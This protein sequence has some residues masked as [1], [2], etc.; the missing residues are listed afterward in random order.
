MVRFPYRLVMYCSIALLFCSCRT[1]PKTEGEV[2]EKTLVRHEQKLNRIQ[3][4]APRFDFGLMGHF[5]LRF[6]GKTTDKAA[7]S[8]EEFR[9]YVSQSL[10]CRRHYHSAWDVEQNELRFESISKTENAGL[11]TEVFAV[12]LCREHLSAHC[13]KPL[14]LRFSGKEGSPLTITVPPYYIRGFLRRIE[15]KRPQN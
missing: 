1:F 10:F 12:P 6:I 11:I 3:I 2:F 7:E 14:V 8:T 5:F 9:L 15:S 13:T 4:Q